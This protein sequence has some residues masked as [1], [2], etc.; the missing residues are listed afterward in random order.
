MST[1]PLA[2][3]ARVRWLYGAGSLAYGIKDAG[4]AYFL[5]FFYNQALG[6][7]G[8]YAGIAILIAM[9]CDAISDP[10]VGIWSDNTHS[11]WGRRHPF[12]YASALP[13]A[14]T[15]FLLWNPPEQLD[16][17]DLF[18]YLTCIA[19]AVRFFVTLYEVP[20]SA[21]VAELTDNYDERTRMLGYRYMM[22]WYGGLTINL[23]QWGVFMVAFGATSRTTYLV[24]GAVGACAMFLA[25][26]VS[27]GGLHRYIPYL[28]R[29]SKRTSYRLPQMLRDLR[30]TL[31]NRNFA[32]LFFAGLF[33]AA[34][35]GV[36]TTFDT[37]IVTHFWGLTPMQ[38]RWVIASL[39]VSALVPLFAAPLL[40]SRWDKKRS[41]MCVYTFQILF[42][43]APVILRLFGWFPDNDS[44]FLYPLIWAH[45]VVNVAMI[46]MFGVLQSSML[47]DVVEHSQ[48]STSRRE[49]GLFFASRSFAQKATH[50]I[51]VLLA[52]TALDVIS[53]PRKAA[54]GT[55]SEDTLWDLGL[56]YGPMLMVLY[57]LALG[58]I[59]RYRISRRG[60]EERVEVLRT[61]QVPAAD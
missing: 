21:M 48:M 6:L 13:A 8:I 11:R 55:V 47:A 4:F 56:I 10:L 34:G 59:S 50:G 29:P 23:A 17:F 46:V 49:E 28:Q 1:K 31:S 16:T 33:A 2:V 39:Y 12:M 58:A 41:V 15:Y 18:L 14:L 30:E 57:L 20:S 37:Y 19:I 25:I 35:A 52:G 26:M 53:F 7:P 42:A 40:T 24:Y 3:N 61:G 38:W 9:F 54:P 51:G 5:L 27:A 22:G 45:A 60:H 44:P 36:A 43:G 32:A